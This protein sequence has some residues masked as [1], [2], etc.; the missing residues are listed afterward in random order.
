MTSSSNPADPGLDG[1]VDGFP[2]YGEDAVHVE[3]QP[4]DGAACYSLDHRW[5][6]A[7]DRSRMD[8]MPTVEPPSTTGRCR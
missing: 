8:T 4:L 3:E 2:R 6:A 5:T 7:R 1:T